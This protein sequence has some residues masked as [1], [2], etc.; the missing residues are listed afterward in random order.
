MDCR[1]RRD[2][3]AFDTQE[4][5]SDYPP[6]MERCLKKLVLEAG[7]MGFQDPEKGGR[8]PAGPSGRKTVP[9]GLDWRQPVYN[10]NCRRSKKL[11][12]VYMTAWS[13]ETGFGGR[14]G[15]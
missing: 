12:P 14:K 13:C 2:N 15:L 3:L 9:G 4:N 10:R 7:A 6:G 1:C 5:D 11:I 8:E